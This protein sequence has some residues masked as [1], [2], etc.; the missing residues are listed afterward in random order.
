MTLVRDF[1]L[2]IACFI[3]AVTATGEELHPT[4]KVSDG[5]EPAQ[6]LDIN[7][8]FRDTLKSKALLGSHR[9]ITRTGVSLLTNTVFMT[10]LS[11]FDGM[12]V[13]AGRKKRDGFNVRNKSYAVPGTTL[14][15]S[16][17][18]TSPLDS[19]QAEDLKIDTEDE[20]EKARLL[21]GIYTIWHTA[22]TRTTV[23][24]RFTNTATTISLSYYCTVRNMDWPT[25]FC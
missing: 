14:I 19:S 21:G 6:P 13:C 22:T 8:D 12:S 2:A 5:Q 9:T 10:C 16:Q 20:K 24:T 4:E 23:T 15:D 3:V 25:V 18:S 7:N 17:Y 11:G 1:L